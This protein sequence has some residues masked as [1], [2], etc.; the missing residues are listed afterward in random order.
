L[1]RYV[2]HENTGLLFSV[3][4]H[5]ALARNIV[6]LAKDHELRATISLSGREFFRREFDLSENIRPLD[7]LFR[8]YAQKELMALK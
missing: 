1:R 4:D 3:E 8:T 6:R 5:Q 7:L 2:D